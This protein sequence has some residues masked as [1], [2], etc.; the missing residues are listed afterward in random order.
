VIVTGDFLALGEGRQ[1]G[2]KRVVAWAA[3]MDFDPSDV[4]SDTFS[5]E[6]PPKSGKL[7]EFPEVD[8]ADWFP[9]AAART[10]LLSAQ[11]TF[12]DRLVAALGA[13]E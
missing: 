3:E 1:A 10:K 5:M 7:R 12:I 8:R 6:W 4:H 13:P 11:V 9:I 2:G